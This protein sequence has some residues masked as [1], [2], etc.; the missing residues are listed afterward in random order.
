MVMGVFIATLLVGMIYYV[1]GIG[2]TIMFRE[3]MQDA[4]DT[5]AFSAAVMHA[6]GMNMIALINMI[7]GALAVVAATMS[8]IAA[9]IGYAAA[10]AG[11]VCAFCGPWCASCCS[12]CPYAIR[13]GLEWRDADSA[14]DNVNDAVDHAMSLLNGYAV[15]I[16]YGVPIAAQA[17]V[18][19]Y[20]TDYYAPVTDFGV[21]LPPFRIELPVED[22]DSNWPCD[23]KVL[24][25]VRLFSP[26]FVWLFGSPSLYMA[27]GI[28]AGELDSQRITRQQCGEGRFQRVTENAQEQGNDAYQ[29]QAFMQGE[30]DRDWSAKGVGIATWGEGDDAGNEYA[31]LAQMGNVSFAQ[32]EFFYD[33]DE[34]D[35]REW[36]WHMEWRA[37]LRRFRLSATG[38]GS[39]AS[40]C[41]GCGP[42]GAL[43]GAIDDLVVH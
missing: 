27:G 14:A 34:P 25:W 40:A 6:R 1:W 8:V 38:L 24:P 7:M 22:D 3:R 30:H 41:E 35:W 29:V 10:A 11:F 23:E 19:A 21:M 43:G 18:M 16:R 9:M 42:L 5:A 32:A 15:G 26:V 20:G 33:E 37:R 17:K 13:H 36:L 4:S 2:D 12:A 28:I 39:V 31:S